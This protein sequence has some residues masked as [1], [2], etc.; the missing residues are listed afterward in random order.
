LNV[1][2]PVAF[3]KVPL[4]PWL[5]GSSPSSRR[6]RADGVGGWA[7]ALSKPA[8]GVDGVGDDDADPI[9]ALIG[10][11][12]KLAWRLAGKLDFLGVDTLAALDCEVCE[13]ICN[14]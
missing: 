8:D 7:Q 14:Q 4:I 3:V 9:I 1:L 12:K 6:G 2:E 11:R 10:Q 13:I 5:S